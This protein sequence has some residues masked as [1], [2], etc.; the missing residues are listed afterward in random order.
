MNK[1]TKIVLISA[2]AAAALLLIGLLIFFSLSRESGEVIAKAENTYN[3]EY[4]SYCTYE[5]DPDI[6]IDGV[7]DESVW[8]GKQW[9]SNTYLANTQDNMPR[10]KVTGFTT[11]YGI[12]IAS[13]AEDSNLVND[14][15][16]SPKLNSS[17]EFYVTADNVGEEKV[18][19]GLYRCQFIIDMRGDAFTVYTNFD[20]AV[21]VDG[22]L[23]SGSTKS[24][25]LEMFIPWE[26]VYVDTAKGVP[27]TFRVLP[28]YRAVLAGETN[29]SWMSLA[30]SSI[31]GTTDFYVFGK[32]GYTNIDREN[33]EL[34]DTKFGY[35]KTAN[36]D[37]SK[38]AEGIVE[39][40]TG[41]EHHKIFFT[42]E[43]GPNYIVETTIV[44]VK[45]LE[46]KYPKAGIYFLGT[47][48]QYYAVWLDMRNLV[49]SV[50]GTKN[51]SKYQIVT[52]NNGKGKWE[53]KSL[54]QYDS[55]NAKAAQREGV[56]LTV[57]KYEGRFWYFV[58]GQFIT[59]EEHSFMDIEVIPGFYSLGADAVY[60]N[61]S[62]RALSG[63]DELKEYLNQRDLYF[64]DAKATGAGGSVSVSPAT[65]KK[66]ESYQITITS[67]SKYEVSSIL[68]NGQEKYEEAKKTATGGVYTVS[69]VKE[70]QEIR[71]DFEKCSGNTFSGQVKG[72]DGP[73]TADII[74]QGQTNPLLR[75]ELTSSGEKG[76]S[77]T[78]PA[79]T[80]KVSVTAEDCKGAS[81]T[82]RVSGDTKKNYTLVASDFPKTVK[83]NGKELKSSFS[84]WDLTKEG[85]GKVSTS[86]AANGKMAPLYFGKTG[87]DFVMEA[88]I[89]YTTDFES[90]K[91]YQPDLMGG[92][93]FNDGTKTGWIVAHGSGTV[94]TGFKYTNRLVDYDMLTYPTKE[95][96][97]FAIAKKGDSLYIY[98]DGELAGVKKW[99]VV[100]PGISS[101][102]ELA[103]GLYV[104]TDKTSDIEFSSY[105]V[106]T[107]T[108]AATAYIEQHVL[109][110]TAMP[111]NPMFA[112]I[113]TVN[114]TALKSL[115]RRWDLT[116]AGSNE[117]Y[118][119]YEL[120]TKMAPL[121]FTEHG[122]T[123]MIEAT[124]EYATD[125]V[126]GVDYQPDLMGGFVFS[127]GKNDGWIV[128]NRTGFA[129][130]GFKYEQYLVDKEVLTY[131][132]KR[133]VKMTA[134]LKGGYAYIY[135]DDIL[136]AKKKISLLVPN[137]TAKTDLAMGLYMI[138]DKEA[139]IKFSN[140][141]IT[142]DATAVTAY[143]ANH[144][145]K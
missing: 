48:G 141:S 63:A 138:T 95:T 110:D 1:K 121:Y 15:Q 97:V 52:V 21:K 34:G 113:V 55:D 69:G 60:K 42:K 89:N 18:G 38:E 91:A 41:T 74:L 105:N 115:V 44:P 83:V 68:I 81:G 37:I 22:E 124:I 20:R 56:K 62:C 59:S 67:K 136:V 5:H 117:V 49:D 70:N 50:N 36:W 23:N 6:Q 139:T 25:V 33:A 132:E 3:A 116:K 47:T 28:T 14:G 4:H 66:G 12:Y 11:D 142:T 16:R 71:V 100:A 87:K 88:T 90:G 94:T 129:Y 31:N 45:A 27:D 101:N 79:G 118:G 51:F 135:F 126:D 140:I 106:Q 145:V 104:I 9:F 122:S 32:D 8:E 109:K 82:V 86:Y 58:D 54:S 96:A 29:T 53:Q 77:A 131:P 137:A 7:L 98:F 10:I 143:I 73:I 84:A 46:N 35:A 65:V 107:G 133:P 130:T 76:F 108:S 13:V 99:S 64:I 119:S 144:D 24:A 72:P 2:A 125:F 92:F 127:D 19:D 26:T 57:I 40:S 128:A 30:Q 120:G 43:Y 61:Y 123:A 75:Y 85:E 114:G 78:I 103:L 80:Y 93:V 39:S 112:K 111:E 17:W 134:A 102:A